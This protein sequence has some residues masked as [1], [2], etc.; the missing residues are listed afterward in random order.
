MRRR[1]SSRP[2]P[3]LSRPFLEH[4]PLADCFIV[5]RHSTHSACE[6]IRRGHGAGSALDGVALGLFGRR[7]KRKARKRSS[8]R[9]ENHIEWCLRCAA[10]TSKACLGRDLA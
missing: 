10:E 5:D 1:R 8:A 7:R 6:N 2:S 4:P 3:Q 9:F